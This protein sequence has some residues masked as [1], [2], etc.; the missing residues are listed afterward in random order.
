[1]FVAMFR[2][3]LFD[4]VTSPA[5]N[6]EWLDPCC[7]RKYTAFIPLGRAIAS[8]WDRLGKGDFK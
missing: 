3:D 8:V 7:R 1:M 4:V 6:N 5:D 2:G